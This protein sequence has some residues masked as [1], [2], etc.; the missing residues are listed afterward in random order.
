MPTY[1]EISFIRSPKDGTR[2]YEIVDLAAR[3]AAASAGQTKISWKGDAAPVVA[4]IPAGVK[5]IWNSVEYT[6]TRQASEADSHFHWLVKRTSGS[7]DVYEEFIVAI[8]DTTTPA[9]Y[10]WES[11]GF[12]EVHLD[13]LGS[14]AYLD[15]VTLV[16]GPAKGVLGSNTTFLFTPPTV[17]V[18]PAAKYIGAK[19][20]GGDANSQYIKGINTPSAED[21]VTDLSNKNKKLKTQEVNVIGNRTE[22]VDGQDVVVPDMPDFDIYAEGNILNFDF[23]PGSTQTKHLADG[24][25]VAANSES[26]GQPLTDGVEVTKS[27]SKKVLGMAINDSPSKGTPTPN[28]VLE[29]KNAA[30]DGIV[31]VAAPTEVTASSTG[32]SVVHNNNDPVN[33]ARHENLSVETGDL[34]DYDD[35]SV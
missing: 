23:S 7:M 2:I 35:Q 32:G 18:T 13:D 26:H 12:S 5:V 11:L 17:K 8:D 34:E 9:T 6:G 28:V 27:Q 22:Q 16:K 25:F 14:L 4:N 29:E 10:F 3:A 24:T 1:T 31:Q 15:T 30:G 20:T 19:V 33:V 21:L